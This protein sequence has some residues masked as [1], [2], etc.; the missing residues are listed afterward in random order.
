MTY[1]SSP[2][3]REALA[4][5][6][7][8]LDGINDGFAEHEHQRSDALSARVSM[9]PA[10]EI[11]MDDWDAL[12]SAVNARLRQAVGEAIMGQ[13]NGTAAPF[14]T[15]VLECVDALEHLQAALEGRRTGQRQIEGSEQAGPG[16]ASSA[17]PVPAVKTQADLA[18]GSAAPSAAPAASAATHPRTTPA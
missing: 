12:L 8:E 10:T 14:R 7:L 2:G 16:N 11:S 18:D 1:R 4:R 13:F 9:R 3:I 6:A 15:M 17:A 5:F